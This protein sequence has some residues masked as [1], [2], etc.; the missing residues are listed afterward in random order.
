VL[1]LP[2]VLRRCDVVSGEFH[3]GELRVRFAPDPSRWPGGGL[4]A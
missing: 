1:T 3:D 2:S 4:D